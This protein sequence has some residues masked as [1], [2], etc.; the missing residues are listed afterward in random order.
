MN[1][2]AYMC[3]VWYSKSSGTYLQVLLESLILF[4]EAFKHG[5]AAKFEGYVRTNAE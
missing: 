1:R 4:D 3:E 2:G 5:D